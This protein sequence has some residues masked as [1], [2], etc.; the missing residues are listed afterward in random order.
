MEKKSVTFFAH[1]S[2]MSFLS[3]PTSA[4]QVHPPFPRCHSLR[5]RF[6]ISCVF[7]LCSL[8]FQA[9]LEEAMKKLGELNQSS[10]NVCKGCN[11]PMDAP[12]PSGDS[13]ALIAK[14]FHFHADCFQC[15]V[16]S[17][18]KNLASTGYFERDSQFYCESCFYEKFHPKCAGK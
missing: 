9:A 3:K 7:F 15:E 14:G 4:D 5:C 11:Q 17:C 13:S 2:R 16:A 8:M 10:A 1:R 18:K 6:T 12:R